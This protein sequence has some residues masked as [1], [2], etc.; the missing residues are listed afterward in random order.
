[1]DY[2]PMEI[3]PG[4]GIGHIQFGL[5]ESELIELL[6]SPD[7]R[8]YTDGENL[9]L[10]YFELRLEFSIEPNNDDRLGWIEVHHPEATLFGQ[11]VIGEPIEYVRNLI[12]T[13]IG[14]EPEYEDYYCVESVTYWENWIELRVNFGRVTNINFGVLYNQA[15]EVLWPIAP[16]TI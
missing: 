8:S 3:H 14:E 6:G 16:T 5:R 11:R 12:E 7:K 2:C 13:V 1:M 9:R 10:Q 15:D 4:K